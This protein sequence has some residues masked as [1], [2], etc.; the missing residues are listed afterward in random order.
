[1]NSAY[2]AQNL[3]ENSVRT[4]E[5]THTHTPNADHKHTHSTH[6]CTDIQTP[7]IQIIS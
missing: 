2:K 3:P 1:M 5:H 4:K 6:P 7:H